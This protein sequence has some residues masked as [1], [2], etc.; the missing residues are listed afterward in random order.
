MLKNLKNLLNA[1]QTYENF[2]NKSIP[3]N[4]DFFISLKML[5]PLFRMPK[6]QKPERKSGFL[7]N[8]N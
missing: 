3:E 8:I 6:K 5:V 7:I 4:G 1:E 2:E